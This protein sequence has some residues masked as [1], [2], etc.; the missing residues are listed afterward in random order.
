MKPSLLPEWVVLS[1][2][3][4]VVVQGKGRDK[5]TE[6]GSVDDEKQGTK[7]SLWEHHR[8]RKYYHI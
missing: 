1:E 5:S 8:T 6:R 2:L 4:K 3:C 7:R